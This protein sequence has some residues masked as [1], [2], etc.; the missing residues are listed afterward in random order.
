M[1]PLNLTEHLNSY[2]IWTHKSCQHS[3]EGGDFYRV[4]VT[5]GEEEIMT[6]GLPRAGPPVV[7]EDSIAKAP[8]GRLSGP[9]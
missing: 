3:T 9:V 5:S 7:F 8:R 1:R 6:A 2:K 4:G